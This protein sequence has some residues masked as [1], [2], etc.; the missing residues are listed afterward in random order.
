MIYF[1]ITYKQERHN[2]YIRHVCTKGFES[3]IKWEGV[4]III[5]CYTQI[6]MFSCDIELEIREKAMNMTKIWLVKL[7]RVSKP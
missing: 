6:I 3:N 5:C 2:V 7:V 1:K 4:I